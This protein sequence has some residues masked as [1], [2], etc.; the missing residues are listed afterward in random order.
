[1]PELRN[2]FSATMT[3]TPHRVPMRQADRWKRGR[4]GDSMGDLVSYLKSVL[5]APAG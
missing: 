1:M 5:D 4:G 3:D 2:K